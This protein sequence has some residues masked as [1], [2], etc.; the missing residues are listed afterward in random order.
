MFAQLYYSSI[1]GDG[2]AMRG[3]GEE[4]EEEEEEGSGIER[5]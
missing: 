5:H 1:G 2:E 3:E 4:E